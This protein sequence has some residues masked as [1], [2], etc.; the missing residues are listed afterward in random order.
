MI[1]ICT[2]G[3]YWLISYPISTM[4]YFCMWAFTYLL[5]ILPEGTPGRSGARLRVRIRSIEQ[6]W[7]WKF[8]PATQNFTNSMLFCNKHTLKTIPL[9]SKCCHPIFAFFLWYKLELRCWVSGVIGDMNIYEFNFCSYLF[10]VRIFRLQKTDLI[11][12]YP[13]I[14]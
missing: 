8:Y 7:S 5:G 11:I 13:C 9:L 3:D 14:L 1:L 12:T 10:L 6:M 4:V 2:W